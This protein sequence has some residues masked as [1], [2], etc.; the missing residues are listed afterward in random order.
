MS[1]LVRAAAL[2]HFSEV[3]RALGGDPER[4]MREAGLRPALIRQQ[5]QL[6]DVA[7][8]ARLLESAARA[9]QCESF[10]L[11][12]AQ[13]REVSNFGPVSLLLLHQPTL[14]HVFRT[15]IEHA[16]LINQSVAIQMEEAGGVVVLRGDMASTGPMRQSI[17]LAIGV[18]FRMGERLLGQCWRPQRV[19]FGH[20][21]PRDRGTHARL[22]RCP[23]EFDAEFNGIVCRGADLDEPNPLADPVLVHYARKVLEA[24][25]TQGPACVGQQVRQALYLALPFSHATCAS[26]AQ[27]MGRSVRTLQRE[28]GREGLSFSELLDSVRQDLA[29]RHVANPRHSIGEVAAMLGYGSHSAF[30][31]WFTAR[32][33]ESP[34][35]WRER[36]G[37]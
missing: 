28:L 24:M 4:A 13:S 23:V 35:A 8:A 32:F 21:A 31:R 6:I 14:R 15:L 18:L 7:L 12:M 2:T 3:L 17:E 26:I 20:P 5:D 22:F 33:G 37:G 27:G 34:L 16:H 9:T 10:G 36:A 25:P 1:T 19:C 30:T 29:Q 11:R